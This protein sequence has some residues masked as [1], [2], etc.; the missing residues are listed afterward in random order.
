[1]HNRLTVSGGYCW[2][3]LLPEQSVPVVEVAV[4]VYMPANECGP[5]QVGHVIEKPTVC[6]SRLRESVIGYWRWQTLLH[7]GQEPLLTSGWLEH[8]SMYSW[9]IGMWTLHPWN[10]RQ[11]IDSAL[12]CVRKGSFVTRTLTT[13]H[14]IIV[15]VPWRSE[16]DFTD[17]KE[18]PNFSRSSV[19]R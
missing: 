4:V 14:I 19:V 13:S 6:D 10:M 2:A 3:I 1:M 15:T 16:Y 7:T 9:F 5:L 18:V 11:Q 17:W 8:S 12:H